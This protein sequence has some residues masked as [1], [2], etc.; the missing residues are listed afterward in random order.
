MRQGMAYYWL[1]LR[2][3][4]SIK[5]SFIVADG[6]AGAISIIAPA[7]LLLLPISDV[8]VANSIVANLTWQIPL[9]TLVLLI[10]ARLLLAPFWI[11]QGMA[12]ELDEARASLQ[13]T[14]SPAA[15]S[16]EEAQLLLDEGNRILARCADESIAPPIAISENW[17]IRTRKFIL[18]NIGPAYSDLWDSHENLPPP[19]IDAGP[20]SEKHRQLW[21]S[22]FTRSK[23]L[24][25]IMNDIRD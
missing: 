19:P 1:W 14:T 10:L 8:D 3:A 23:R 25:K 9:A 17:R 12:R 2:T 15:I 20:R 13:K 16:R 21:S 4:F 6:I 7:I 24:E 18:D 22:V 11:H 5:R